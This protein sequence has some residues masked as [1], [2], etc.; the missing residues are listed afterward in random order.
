M[1]LK[2]KLQLIVLGAAIGVLG[3]ALISKVLLYG[4]A[5]LCFLAAYFDKK[6]RLRMIGLGILMLVLVFKTSV[7]ICILI[8]VILAQL[9]K[10]NSVLFSGGASPKE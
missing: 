10:D 2:S 3:I 1:S 6:L 9:S 5:V 4:F 7:G 8:F